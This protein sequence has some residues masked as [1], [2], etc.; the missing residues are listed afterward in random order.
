M[1]NI[2]ILVICLLAIGCNRNT[3]GRPVIVNKFYKPNYPCICEFYYDGL[4]CNGRMFTDSCSLYHIG[5]TIK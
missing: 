3:N 1:K 4:G 2:I 5:D